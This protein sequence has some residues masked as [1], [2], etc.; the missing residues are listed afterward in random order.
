MTRANQSKINPVASPWPVLAK[1]DRTQ[2][3]ADATPSVAGTSLSLAPTDTAWW[4]GAMKA[5]PLYFFWVPMATCLEKTCLQKIEYPKTR[6]SLHAP[7]CL[8]DY[9]DCKAKPWKPQG[10]LANL[11]PLHCTKLPRDLCPSAHVL[12]SLGVS[13]VYRLLGFLP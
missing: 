10:C 1:I 13:C 5:T 11:N 6:R 9:G 8:H 2:G 4:R 7:Q 3:G 12:F